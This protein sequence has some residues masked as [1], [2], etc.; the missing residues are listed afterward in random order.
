MYSVG[1][2]AQPVQAHLRQ[3]FSTKAIHML[4][5]IVKKGLNF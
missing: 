2:T 3:Q 1:L 4:K 5:L